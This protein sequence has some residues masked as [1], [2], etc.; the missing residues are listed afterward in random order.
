LT[1]IL[2]AA[3]S[4]AKARA[5]TRSYAR[6]VPTVCAACSHAMRCHGA[7]CAALRCAALCCALPCLALPCLALPFLR[8]LILT[9]V[10]HIHPSMLRTMS[11]ARSFV[12]VLSSTRNGCTTTATSGAHTPYPS[13]STTLRCRHPL[14]RRHLHLHRRMSLAVR[15]LSSHIIDRLQTSPSLPVCLSE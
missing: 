9:A 2:T 1:R 4:L 3:S 10:T 8:G 11:F 6:T 14:H 15:L 13:A 7:C 12:Q 5:T